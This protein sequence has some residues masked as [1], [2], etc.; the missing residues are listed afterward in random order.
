MSAFEPI[1]VGVIVERVKAA[2]PWIDWIWRPTA[3]LAGEPATPPWTK[4]AE[5]SDRT[6]FYA[7]TAH[8]ELHRSETKNYRDNLATGSPMLW[9]VLRETGAEPPYDVYTVT[10]DPAEGEGMTAAGND[11]VESVPMP[12]Q[13][14]DVVAAFIAEHHVDDVFV[15]RQ[16]DRVNTEALARRPPARRDK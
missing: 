5:G 16:R 13:V 3:V 15:K 2:S 14:R 10:A 7:G 9:V 6:S 4:I 11:I 1:P 8:I 12:D